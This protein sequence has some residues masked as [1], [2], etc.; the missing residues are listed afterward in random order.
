MNFT[1]PNL[2]FLYTC[3]LPKYTYTYT[4]LCM[5][6]YPFII[7]IMENWT[8]LHEIIDSF[9]GLIKI[10]KVIWYSHTYRITILLLI[11]N[12]YFCSFLNST[13]TEQQE[14]VKMKRQVGKLGEW[15]GWTKFQQRNHV[16]P[17]FFYFNSF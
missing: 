12:H 13:V 6:T 15:F 8:T 10:L 5:H 3:L 11:Q 16:F 1:N 7:K 14:Q 4:Y 17:H 9:L 2:F